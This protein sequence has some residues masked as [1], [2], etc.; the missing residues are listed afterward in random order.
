TINPGTG[1]SAIDKSPPVATSCPADIFR[2]S[3]KP[4]SIFWDGHVFEDDKSVTKI[5][6]NYRRVSTTLSTL[7]STARTIRVD[8]NSIYI[9]HQIAA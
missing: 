6:S 1:G 5:E 7:R 4:M 2:Q 8:V 9:W 3:T